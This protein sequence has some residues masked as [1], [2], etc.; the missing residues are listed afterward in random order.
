MSDMSEITP[1][2]APRMSASFG[3][4]PVPTWINERLQRIEES[5]THYEA[6]LRGPHNAILNSYFPASQNFLVK[7][8]ARLRQPVTVDDPEQPGE[9]VSIDSNGQQVHTR[10][11]DGVPDFVVSYAT[12]DPRGDVPWLIWE[13]KRHSGSTEHNVQVDRYHAWARAFSENNLRPGEETTV[14]LVE[15][16]W[17]TIYVAIHSPSPNVGH[18]SFCRVVHA[19]ILSLA[20]HRVLATIAASAH[21]HPKNQ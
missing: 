21:G 16:N 17:V 6:S 15:G 3:R 19:H 2:F 20:L 12:S 18:Y 8:E 1:V 5:G 9:R 13:L 14:C 4:D 7:T 10:S 11:D